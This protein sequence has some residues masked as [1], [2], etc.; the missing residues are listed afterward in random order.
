MCA[1]TTVVLVDTLGRKAIQILGFSMMAALYLTVVNLM[2][3]HGTSII[4]F[5]IPSSYALAIY[6]LTF[7]IDFG[8]NTTTFVIPAEVYLTSR[9]TTGHGISAAAGKAGAA[10]VTLLF[11]S[12]QLAIGIRGILI[13]YAIAAIAGALLSIPLKEPKKMDLEAISE[14]IVPAS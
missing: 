2:I 10:I 13:I 1:L 8:P 6:A 11:P 14:E 4:G 7:F 12:L 3:A 5:L 9:R